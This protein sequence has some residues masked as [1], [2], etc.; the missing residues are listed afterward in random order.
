MIGDE[1]LEKA[2]SFIRDKAKDYAKAKAQHLHL[3]EFRKSKKAILMQHAETLGFKTSAAQEREAYANN[4]YVELL[5]G[6]QAAVEIEATLY[7]QLKAAELAIDIWRT[8]AANERAER[9]RYG[10]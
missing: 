3:K 10:A 8:R 7:Y 4:E 1:R 6:L 2:L 9:G 5:K